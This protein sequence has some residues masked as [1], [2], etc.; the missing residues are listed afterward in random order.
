MRKHDE[1]KVAGPC[2]QYCKKQCKCL[3]EQQL[4]SAVP[5][6]AGN[7]PGNP[8]RETIAHLLYI[9]GRY[10]NAGPF[11]ALLRTLSAGPQSER[12]SAAS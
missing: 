1:Q 12:K 5:V 3:P 7:L 8:I 6:P 11:K 10:K 9:V 2:P 4:P